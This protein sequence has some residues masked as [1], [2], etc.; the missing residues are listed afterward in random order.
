MDV[1]SGVHQPDLFSAEVYPCGRCPVVSNRPVRPTNKPSM[2]VRAI[3]RHRDRRCVVRSSSAT[4]GI[5]G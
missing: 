3:L 5:S 2:R 4:Q 1:A